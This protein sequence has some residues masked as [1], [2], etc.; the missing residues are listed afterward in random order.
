MISW[1]ENTTCVFMSFAILNCNL[2]ECV[3][4]RLNANKKLWIASIKITLENEGKNQ[5]L[6][7]Y[8]V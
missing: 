8:V 7:R 4:R 2:Y 3:E 6:T 5:S 1:V